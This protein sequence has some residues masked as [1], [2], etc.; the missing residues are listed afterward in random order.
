MYGVVLTI[1]IIICVLLIMLVLFQAGKS[2]GLGG[3]MG[4]GSSDAIFTSAGGSNLLKKITAVLAVLFLVTSLLLAVIVANKPRKSLMDIM[5]PTP[6]LPE[7]AQTASVPEASTET[8]A[9]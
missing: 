8:V 5:P 2:L 7:V 6:T 9:Q 3:L 4:G 1:H